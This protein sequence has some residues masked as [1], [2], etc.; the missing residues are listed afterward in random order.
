MTLD[1]GDWTTAGGGTVAMRLSA[2]GVPAEEAGDEV[3]A[4]AVRRALSGDAAAFEEIVRRHERRVYGLAR[5][6]L[7]RPED[8]E[9]AAQ[10]AFLRLFRS[11]GRLD[12]ARPIGPYL[13]RVTL[14]VC[15]DLGRRRRRRLAVPLEEMTA[16][17]EP[18]G[19]GAD[20][21]ASAGLAEERRIAA[22]ALRTLP[23]RQR[24][25]LVLRDLQGLSTREV[26]A[27]LG[28]TEVTVRTQICRAR[29][30]VKEFRDRVLGAHKER[31]S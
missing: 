5:R 6:L 30:K 24:A 20:P 7:G 16:S 25:A 13:Y 1:H 18:A 19:A 15:R 17:E 4:A 12:P 9:D 8:A 27:V 22:A 23:E 3:G 11:L 10:E 21:A 29:L 26:A 14:N 31:P 28:T 2:A